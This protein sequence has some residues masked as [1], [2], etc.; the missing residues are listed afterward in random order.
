VNGLVIFVSTT[1][2]AIAAIVLG[3]RRHKEHPT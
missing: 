1:V 2:I 3:R